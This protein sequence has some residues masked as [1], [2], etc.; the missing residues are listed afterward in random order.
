MASGGMIAIYIISWLVSFCVALLIASDT[1]AEQGLISPI[2][3][4][5]SCGSVTSV[6][7]I[8]QR[9][10][11]ELLQIE[12]ERKRYIPY[13]CPNFK[14]GDKV[15]YSIQYLIFRNSDFVGIVTKVEPKPTN[16]YI[17]WIT[18]KRI[19]GK[20]EGGCFS[21]QFLRKWKE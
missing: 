7:D 21:E 13:E 14:I 12:R 18:V 2:N 17:H 6:M 15:V 1:P 20:S 8:K 4:E 9:E 3:I 16:E 10:E 19:H 11:Q 5:H